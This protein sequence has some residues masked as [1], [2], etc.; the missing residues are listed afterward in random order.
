MNHMDLLQGMVR[1][2]RYTPKLQLQ[3][4]K[5]MVRNE[6]SGSRVNP[7]KGCWDKAKWVGPL[8]LWEDWGILDVQVRWA[9]VPTPALLL[10]IRLRLS[11]ALLVPPSNLWGL[12]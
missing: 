3:P 7:G 5:E 9:V 2:H 8:R 1:K 4:L 10:Q 11:G 12:P 6:N